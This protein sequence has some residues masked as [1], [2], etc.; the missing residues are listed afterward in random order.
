MTIADAVYVLTSPQHYRLPRAQVA[1]MLVRLVRIREFKVDNRRAVLRALA[2]FGRTARL[3][4]GDAMTAA[5]MQDRRILSI[6]SYDRDFDRLP[7]LT[8]QE[9]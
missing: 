8:R 9:P 2:L 5:R 1:A 6:Y 7:G 4:F 3:D